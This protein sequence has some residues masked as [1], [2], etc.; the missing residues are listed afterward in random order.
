[1]AYLVKLATLIEN[2]NTFQEILTIDEATKVRRIDMVLRDDNT[3]Y[4]MPFRRKQSTLKVFDGVTIYPAPSDYDEISFLD[5]EELSYA[6]RARFRY[7]SFDQFLQ[8]IDNRNDLC[9]IMDGEQ[10]MI[11]CRYKTKNASSR[12]VNNAESIALFTALGDASGL[13]LDKVNMKEGSACVR[14]SITKVTNAANVRNTF[15]PTISD[16]N[17]KQKYYFRWVFFDSSGVPTSV[18][19]NFGTD[20]SNYL[21]SNAI[22]TQFSGQ[23]FKPGAWNLLAFDLNTANVAGTINSNSFAYENIAF[24]NAP[25]GTYYLDSSYL[26]N[27]ELLDFWYY[28]INC[29]K[30]TLGVYKQTFIDPTTEQYDINDSLIGTLDFANYIAYRATMVSAMDK[31]NDK[32]RDNASALEK[33]S[34][35]NIPNRYQTIKPVITN[36]NWRF[37]NDPISGLR[38]FPKRKDG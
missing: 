30:T 28:H 11:G 4:K 16:T 14:F 38:R 12:L 9:E 18:V 20:A 22:T 6:D 19:L 23:A 33:E 15:T 34:A 7:Q 13:V 24:S 25:S 21:Y 26:R 1:M 10:T 17:Y 31:G 32:L 37:R 3:G 36:L 27:W 35:T 8:D 29:V 2:M 5:N